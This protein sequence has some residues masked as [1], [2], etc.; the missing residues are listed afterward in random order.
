M[1]D[2]IVLSQDDAARA[3]WANVYAAVMKGGNRNHE[4][5]S[6]ADR[7]VVDWMDRFGPKRYSS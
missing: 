7:A 2:E 3:L 5:A 6:R 1:G 4:A